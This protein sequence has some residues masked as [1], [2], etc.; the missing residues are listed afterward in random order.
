VNQAFYDFDISKI[1][2]EKFQFKT[3]KGQLIT[4][5]SVLFLNYKMFQKRTV[6]K[7]FVTLSNTKLDDSKLWI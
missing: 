7:H 2:K 3:N 4:I 1:L 6:L 5:P